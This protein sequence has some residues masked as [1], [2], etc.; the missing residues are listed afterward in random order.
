M[1]VPFFRPL[2]GNSEIEAAVAVLRSGWL[3]TG[4][5]CQEFE[6]AFSA[7][8]GDGVE[9]VAVNSATAGLHLAA[10]ACG[11]RAG[12]EVLVPTLTFTATAG[13]FH[14]MGAEPI[15]VDVDPNTL[16]ID[17]NDAERKMTSRCKAIV[18]VHFGGWPCD[19]D[20]IVAFARRHGLRVI[21]DAAHALPARRDGR[22]V[23][24]G[25]SDACVFS[26]YANKTITTGEGGMLVTRDPE[27][28]QRARMMRSHGFDRDAFDR[29][30]RIGAAWRYDIIAAGYKYNL[31][32]LAAAIGLEQLKRV[33]EFQE[34]RQRIAEH[35]NSALAGLP[36]ELPSPA[37]ANG[38]HAW[39]LY[40]IRVR[41]EARC[42][43][44]ELIKRLNQAEIGVSVH[45]LPLHMTSYWKARPGAV[46]AFPVATRHYQ[47]SVTLPLFPDMTLDEADQVIEVV[48]TVG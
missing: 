19:M 24:A 31:T 14:Q 29:F 12:D 10:E 1:S 46:G 20:A 28:A 13:A 41:P 34:A 32:D 47:Q 6:K 37:P 4:H 7:F 33:Y 27:I 45:Y 11:V 43:R 38:L 2:I 3:T 48:K 5:K 18:P 23:G 16:T 40:P 26:F 36:L 39:H 35:Y 9:A 42:G 22:L 25:E 30:K 8:L 44:D 17:L 15:L 21:E